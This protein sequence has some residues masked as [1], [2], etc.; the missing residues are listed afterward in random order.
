MKTLREQVQ[1]IVE[2]KSSIRRKQ[3]DLIKLG[4]TKSDI[5]VILSSIKVGKFD[6]SKLTFGVEIECYNCNRYELENKCSEKGVDCQSQSYNHRDTKLYY[7][8]V[9]DSSLTGENSNEVVSPV[10][11]GKKGMSSLE[12]VCAALN[13]IGARVNRSCGLHVHIGAENI[14]NEHFVRIIK[15]YKRL[16]RVIDTFMP[17]SRRGDNNQFCRTLQDVNIE[18][19]NTKSDAINELGTRYRKVNA[20]AY[21]RHRTIEFR[22]HSG[23]VDFEKISNWVKFLAKLVEYSEK[24][25]ITECVCIEDIPFLNDSDKIY[26]TNRRNQLATL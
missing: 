7:K 26:F 12:K 17:E 8:I 9:S 24:K 1:E 15:N 10:L 11:Q 16:E 13:E 21:L 2:K 18:S 6:F 22:Q 23:T 4:L 5:D 3:I 14:S 25:E 19:C 20:H